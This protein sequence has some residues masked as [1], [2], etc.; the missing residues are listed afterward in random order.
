MEN[1]K[2]Q[3]G[4]RE[5]VTTLVVTGILFVVGLLI[6]ANVTNVTDKIL[7]PDSV[8]VLN[9]SIT[10]SVS[11]PNG[12]NSTLLSLAGYI[13]NSETVKNQSAPNPTLTRNAEYTVTLTGLSGA[14][15]TRGNFTLLNITDTGGVTG[16]NGTALSITYSRNILSAAQTTNNNLQTTVL[17][18]FSLGVIALIVLA[19]VVI[20][21]VL[22][23]LGSQ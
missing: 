9:E 18:S 2:G 17:D 5:L 20:L 6:F 7:D 16:Y 22:F 10:I 12:D 3:T 23:T 15:A 14:I 1:K 13:E 8:T 4:I 11:T 21:G 19:A